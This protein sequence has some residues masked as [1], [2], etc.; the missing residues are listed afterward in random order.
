MIHPF[1]FLSRLINKMGQKMDQLKKRF[2]I[3]EWMAEDFAGV[4]SPADKEALDAW[5]AESEAHEAEY[6]ELRAELSAGRIR[7][8]ESKKVAE[9]WMRFVARQSSRK[10]FLKRWMGY[11]AAVA[12]LLGG[13]GVALWMQDKL[14]EPE[15]AAVRTIEVP[16]GQVQLI[17]GDGRKVVLD[18]SLELA[19]EEVQADVKPGE[20]T[21]AYA[22]GDGKETVD[23]FNTLVV[24]KGGEYKVVLADGSQVWLNSETQFRYPVA[25]AGEERQV[26]LEGEAYFEVAADKARPFVVATGGGARVKVLGTKFNVAS[27]SEEEEVMTTL[28]EG[29]VEVSAASVCVRLQPDEQAVF[30]KDAGV[31][32]KRAVD[33]SQYIAWKDGKFIF[34]NISLGQ[35]MRQLQRW[36]DITVFYANTG[37]EDYR[38]SGDLKKYDDF[39]QIIKMIEEVAGLKINITNNNCVV[40]GGNRVE[41]K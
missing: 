17:L 5:R 26:F 29:S 6:R 12:L 7:Q 16:Q 8:D 20:R 3:A 41:T 24:P 40:I 38:L 39:S 10:R 32:G 21:I 9:A 27:Y 25:F 30:E 1:F 18:D 28:A 15:V 36:Y 14:S 2:R 4:I 31:I 37:L 34:D 23:V 35:I 22:Q 13:V 19:P 33:A 11:A